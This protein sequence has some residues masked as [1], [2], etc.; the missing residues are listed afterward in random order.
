MK[1]RSILI[2]CLPSLAFS[3]DLVEAYQ[4][5]L[6]DSQSLAFQEQTTLAA[7]S[8]INVAW[9]SV[10]PSPTYSFNPGLS[11]ASHSMTVSGTLFDPT[12]WSAIS[13]AQEKN[14]VSD[15][16]LSS[17]K[18]TFSSSLLHS[19]LEILSADKSYQASLRDQK[20][21]AQMVKE[22]QNK[23][24]AGL[25]ARVELV[26][27][28]AKYDHVTS[29]AFAMKANFDLALVKIS[30]YFSQPIEQIQDLSDEVALDDIYAYLQ[31]IQ[32]TA[33]PSLKVL[34]GD[35]Q[36]KK[37]TLEHSRLGHYFLPKISYSYTYHEDNS[38]SRTH[39]LQWQPINFAN[40]ASEKSLKYAYQA[41]LHQRKQ[42]C[43]EDQI[44]KKQFQMNIASLLKQIQAQYHVQNSNKE[45]LATV[46]ASFDA[47][48]RTTAEV[49][50]AQSL[51][52]ASEKDLFLLKYQCLELL[53]QY[54]QS[55][56]MTDFE[57]IELINAK[58]NLPLVLK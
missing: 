53:F 16:Q 23:F 27:A 49:L 34:I 45:K 41:A 43:I 47:G 32:K 7:K 10:L 13:V 55:L 5:S 29:Q 31:E 1:L 18:Q 56:G 50:Q 36:L 12:A 9:A 46:R 11:S 51:W 48:T 26:E 37:A 25:I 33:Q 30:Q 28:Q 15:L 20:A 22:L 24:E 21:S 42:A 3:L 4:N 8:S 57:A 40:L 2:A 19:Y 52:I 14:K 39:S 44:E 38:K 6:A 17:F 35:Q 58:L 54:A